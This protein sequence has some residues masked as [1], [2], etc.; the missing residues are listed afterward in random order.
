MTDEYRSCASADHFVP[1]PEVWSE[2]GVTAM[3]GY[4]YTR[5]PNLNFPPPIKIRNRN[6]RSRRLLEAWKERMLRVA[7]ERGFQTTPF[8]ANGGR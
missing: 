6:F 2:L 5:D 7:L 8:F 4:R 1:D 3:T